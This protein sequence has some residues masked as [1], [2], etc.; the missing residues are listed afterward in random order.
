[1]GQLTYLWCRPLRLS[2]A[3]V[4]MSEPVYPT[5]IATNKQLT[6]WLITVTCSVPLTIAA[7]DMLSVL[8][9]ISTACCEDIDP[10]LRRLVLSVC[11]TP[12]LNVNCSC[13]PMQL[14]CNPLSEPELEQALEQE[15][16]AALPSCS[17]MTKP[18]HP[19]LPLCPPKSLTRSS[20]SQREPAT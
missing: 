7:G 17:G 3:V 6:A 20:E 18:S 14:H 4:T 10:V 16:V 13:V 11:R 5:R 15:T 12:C 1:M 19:S 2:T 9:E 8:T